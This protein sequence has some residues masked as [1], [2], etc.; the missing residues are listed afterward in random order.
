MDMDAPIVPECCCLCYESDAGK[1]WWHGDGSGRAA[2]PAAR[3]GKAGVC[4]CNG[5]AERDQTGGGLIREK[6]KWEE[7]ERE[8]AAMGQA[9]EQGAAERANAN[10]NV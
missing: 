7:R 3:S 8:M 1:G 6:A 9:K 5:R 4:V 2:V 10:A